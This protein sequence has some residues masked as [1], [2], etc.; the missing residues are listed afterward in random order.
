MM[1][2]NSTVFSKK[3]CTRRLTFTRK[4]SKRCKKRGHFNSFIKMSSSSRVY[5]KNHPRQPVTVLEVQSLKVGRAINE[6]TTTVIR[7]FRLL[8]VILKKWQLRSRRL[9]IQRK[10]RAARG[11]GS[12]GI[13]IML[14][15]WCLDYEKQKNCSYI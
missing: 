9:F 2:E 12:S 15:Y 1:E 10:P 4:Q 6:L 14:G 7:K 3:C 11:S 13:V 8:A 5:N